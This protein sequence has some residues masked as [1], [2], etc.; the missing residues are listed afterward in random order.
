MKPDKPPKFQ[1][2][3]LGAVVNYFEYM[4]DL[5]FQQLV[6]FLVGLVTGLLLALLIGFLLG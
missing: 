2:N 6:T 4:T 3:L 5:Q 1:G